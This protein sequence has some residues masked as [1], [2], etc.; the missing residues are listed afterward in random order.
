ML[1]EFEL[2]V[3]EFFVTN[4]QKGFGADWGEGVEVGSFA[5]GE[6]QG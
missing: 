1:D 5:A 3:D 2:V 4:G 6:D